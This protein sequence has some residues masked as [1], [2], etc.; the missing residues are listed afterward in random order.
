MQEINEYLELIGF[1]ENSLG[2]LSSTIQGIEFTLTHDP[3]AGY[4][5]QYM[6]VTSRCA[7]NSTVPLGRKPTL[8]NL[9]DAFRRVYG[10]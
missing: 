6:C 1:T 2:F 10:K 3:I 4:A 9:E 5:L 7:T 8:E